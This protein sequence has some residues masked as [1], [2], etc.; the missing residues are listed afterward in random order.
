MADAQQRLAESRARSAG[1]TARV[2]SVR[3]SLAGA[4]AR[5][6]TL[7]QILNDRSYTAETVQKLF[8]VQRQDGANL[9]RR[10]R[11]RRL[12]RSGAAV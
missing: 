12:R 10:R 1:V 4:R 3:D 6:E 2:R 8:A 5:R 11:A 9:P 7:E